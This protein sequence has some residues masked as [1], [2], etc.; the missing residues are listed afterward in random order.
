[1]HNKNGACICHNVLELS[2]SLFN[3]TLSI[4]RFTGLNKEDDVAT[5]F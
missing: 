1:M 4:P 3:D 5:M 2:F